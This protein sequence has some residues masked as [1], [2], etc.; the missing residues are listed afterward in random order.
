MHRRRLLTMLGSTLAL[1]A[2]PVRAQKDVARVTWFSYGDARS[3]EGPLAAF[4]RGMQQHG[5]VLG[6]DVTIDV[7]MGD[8][9]QEKTHRLADELVARPPR[10]V[11]AQGYAIRALAQRTTTVPIVSGYSGDIVEAKLVASHARPGGNVTGIQFLAT[12]LVGKRM[13]LLRELLPQLARVAVIADPGHAGMKLERAASQAAA[14]KLQV[15]VDFHP[16]KSAAEIEPALDAA[17]AG[18]AQALVVFPDSVTLAGRD[19]IAAYAIR[20]R[21]PSISGW[22]SFAEAGLLL[23]YGPN[24]SACWSRLAYYVDRILKGAKAAD[25]P[26]EMPTTVEMIVNLKTA[27][28]IGTA[29]PRSLLL[30]ADRVI[31]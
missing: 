9:S 10:V 13:E 7:L 6:R 3:V 11:V 18:G 26:I 21:L 23:M 29:V 31:D 5:Y 1:A 2:W 24:L 28:A 12:D 19:R 4:N 30:R 17:R 14:D 8:F 16:V 20:H 25:L 15:R 27:K 22:D